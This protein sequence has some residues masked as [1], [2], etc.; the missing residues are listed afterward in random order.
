MDAFAD[1]VQFDMASGKLDPG[2]MPLVLAA[3]RRWHRDR[4]WQGWRYHR[5]GMSEFAAR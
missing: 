4:V 3:L 2:D 1:K 5:N